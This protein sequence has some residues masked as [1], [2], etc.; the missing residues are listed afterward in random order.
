M[1][2]L[3]NSYNHMNVEF[4]IAKSFA[5]PVSSMRESLLE[6]QQF[7]N[8]VKHTHFNMLQFSVAKKNTII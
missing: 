2:T 8:N 5:N 7:P 4:I 6:S 3:M 1:Y